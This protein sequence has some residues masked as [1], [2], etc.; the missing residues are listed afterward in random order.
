MTASTLPGAVARL[1][2]EWA[3]RLSRREMQ[4]LAY[5]LAVG[6][7]GGWGAHAMGAPL[8]WML[9]P[10]FACMAFALAGQ[11]VMVPIWLR[12]LF[13]ALIG[14]FLG[15]SFDVEAA[16]E[17]ARW[18]VTIAMAVLY[19]PVGGA[20]CYL[21]FRHVARMPRGTALLSGLPGGVT[22]VALFASALGGDERRVALSQSLRVAIVVLLAPTIAFGWLGLPPPA[23]GG[24]AGPALIGAGDA[25]ILAAG[26]VALW[27]GGARLGWPLPYMIGPLVASALL[28]FTGVVEGALPPALV[29]LSLLV[30]GASIGTRFGGVPARLFLS[31]VGWS[32]VGTLLLMAI[33]GLF[34]FGAHWWLGVDLFA[35]LLA[36]APGGVAEMSLIAIAIDADPSFVAT[37]H[38]ARIFAILFALPALTSALGR[39][40]GA[41]PEDGSER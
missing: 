25:V 18:P 26:S 20:A 24:G 32:L 9:G 38:M 7:A 35:A 3:A 5:G 23:P 29:E 15:E 14:L 17:I 19:V 16:G 13:M 34:A 22:A 11:P 39:F 2:A 21:L 30:C 10:L 6:A 1:R 33:S 28:R 8:A 36:F 41:T 31:T 37:H 40:I 27:A 12:T 4:R